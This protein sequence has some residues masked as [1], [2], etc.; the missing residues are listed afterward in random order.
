MGAGLRVRDTQN[1]C[2]RID[3]RIYLDVPKQTNRRRFLFTDLVTF[4]DR[5]VVKRPPVNDKHTHK[6]S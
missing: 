5:S 6:H 1:K 4:P 2:Q 3:M